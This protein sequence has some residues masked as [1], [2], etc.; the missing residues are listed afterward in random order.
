MTGTS[1]HDPF[2]GTSPDGVFLKATV[3]FAL[4]REEVILRSKGSIS[5]G[6]AF[7]AGGEVVEFKVG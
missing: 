1:I 5:F 7:D 2:P 6:H 3:E 4:K